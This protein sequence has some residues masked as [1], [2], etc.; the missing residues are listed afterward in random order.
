[1]TNNYQFCGQEGIVVGENGRHP[2][3]AVSDL[4][5]VLDAP[6]ALRVF[7]NYLANLGV[8]SLVVQSYEF[9]QEAGGYSQQRFSISAVSDEPIE[10]QL[11]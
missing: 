10:L 5:K 8:F 3:N 6:I 7:S 9:P 11:S 2:F 1:M 4:K